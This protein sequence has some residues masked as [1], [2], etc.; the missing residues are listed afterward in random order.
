M[1]RPIAIG[2]EPLTAFA[3][4][5]AAAY[6]VRTS[7]N[8][9]INSMPNPTMKMHYLASL[10]WQI[11][12]RLV[13]GCMSFN[14]FHILALPCQTF[15]PFCKVVPPNVWPPPSMLVSLTKA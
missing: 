12:H 6:T 2:G 5:A 14:C 11:T 3:S 7:T 4:S 8:V 1:A 10:H 15:I 13:E 9:M